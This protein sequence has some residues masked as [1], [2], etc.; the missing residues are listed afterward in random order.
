MLCVVK[1][2]Y[3]IVA[4][5]QSSVLMRIPSNP[6]DSV[7]LTFLLRCLVNVLLL[8]H[9]ITNMEIW[10]LLQSVNLSVSGAA[11]HLTNKARQP[12]DK[13]KDK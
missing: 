8:Y 4:Q 7:A 9:Y 11:Q 13:Q 3:Y 2:Y 1:H 5:S 6:G 10:I 12:T